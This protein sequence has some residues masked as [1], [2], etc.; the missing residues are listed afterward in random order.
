MRDRLQTDK[1]PEYFIEPPTPTQPP[2]LSRMGNNYR[3]KCGNTLWLASKGSHGSFHMW[4][5]VW[6]AGKTV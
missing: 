2:N 6:V 5:D 4:I 1:P 3:P